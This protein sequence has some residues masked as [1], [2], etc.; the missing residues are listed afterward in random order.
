MRRFAQMA[1]ACLL[2]ISL[3]CSAIAADTQQ[4]R[5]VDAPV[6]EHIHIYCAQL[7]PM[8]EFLTK[9][10]DAQ[11]VVRRK[12]GNDDGAVINMGAVPLFIQQQATFEAGKAGAASYDHIGLRVIDIE[13]SIKKATDAPGGK[14][15]RG[16]QPAGAAKTAFVS[17]PE[18][19]LIELIQRPKQ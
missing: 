2:C 9:A 8:I 15:V 1:S 12:F 10:F 5:P 14:L 18:G 6:L 13:A 19:L 11:V 7:E 16:I 3:T 4:A 17:G